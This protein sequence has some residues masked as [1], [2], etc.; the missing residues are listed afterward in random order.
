MRSGVAAARP[1][2]RIGDADLVAFMQACLPRLGLRWRGF[3][4]VRRIVRRRLERRLAELGLPD[5]GAYRSRLDAHAEEWAVLDSLCWIPVSRFY[6]DRAVFEFL[7]QV[8]LPELSAAAV[9]QGRAALRGWSVGCAAGEEPYTLAIVWRRRVAPRFPG[10]ALHVVATDVDPEAIAHAREA[11]YAPHMLRDLPLDLAARAF[12]STPAGARLRAEYR[13]DVEFLV[14][15]V[16]RAAPPGRFDLVLCRNL[17]FTYFD[18]ATQRRVLA[19]LVASLEPGGALVLGAT[20]TAPADRDGLVPWS[21]RLRVYRACAG[22]DVAR[23]IDHDGDGARTR[24][25]WRETS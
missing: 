8:V 5:L 6:R 10:L 9:A 16:R 21:A 4:K 13:Q 22:P 14:Q 23:G 25:A 3:R 2:A 12:T 11:V 15:D 17:V 24:A 1:P 7:E 19:R 18:D 20:E